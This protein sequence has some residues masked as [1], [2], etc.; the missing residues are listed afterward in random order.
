M[1]HL[2]KPKTTFNKK[3]FSSTKQPSGAKKFVYKRR[4]LPFLK[5]I[6]FFACLVSLAYVTY[7]L[8]FLSGLFRVTQIKVV[9]VKSFVNGTDLTEVVRGNVYG[10]SIFS[11]NTAELENNLLQNFQGAKYINVYKTF[12]AGINVE[13]KERVPLALVYNDNLESYF[14]V[15]EDGYVLGVVDDST[16]NLPKIKYE[17]EIRIGLF[18]N[19]DMIP[20][21]LDL[22]NAISENNI[23]VSSMSFYP[24][25][26]LLY[27]N[28]GIEVFIDNAKNKN[29]SVIVLKDLLNQ[30]ELE[31]QKDMQK[32]KKIDLRYDKVIVSYE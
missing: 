11:I 32:I 9:G 6:P 24:S 7:Y 4:M 1:R 21:Y 29:G 23:K 16:T 20:I 22:V 17:G 2:A 28:D 12:P 26:A 3:R 19:K 18:I 30:L 8:L 15:D 27:V 10:Q 31:S 25:Y 13:V 5:P 14:M